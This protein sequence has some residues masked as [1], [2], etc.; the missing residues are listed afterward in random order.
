MAKNARRRSACILHALGYN[1]RVSTTVQ[2]RDVPD[3]VV[4]I[5]KARAEARGQSLAALLRDLMAEEA[6]TPSISELMTTIAGREPVDVSTEEV[7]EMIE[8]GRR[9]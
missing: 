1:V 7:R 6:A 5:L 3:E 2:I 9:R 4:E 8:D